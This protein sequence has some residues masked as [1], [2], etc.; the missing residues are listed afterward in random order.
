MGLEYYQPTEELQRTAG[1]LINNHFTHLSSKRVEFM[2]VQSRDSKGNVSAPKTKGKEM[3]GRASV[4]SGKNAWLA[5]PQEDQYRSP[6]K[7]HVVE[8]SKPT[9]DALEDRPKSR[10]ALL[11]HELSHC[12]LDEA[13]E[14]CIAPHSLEDFTAVVRRYGPDWNADAQAFFQAGAEQLPLIRLMEMQA[15]NDS[16]LFDCVEDDIGGHRV[17]LTRAD[18]MRFWRRLELKRAGEAAADTYDAK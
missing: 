14:A 10:E 16:A 15:D 13:G 4:V 3:W 8:V 9:W 6:D 17:R 12:D 1:Y 7:F 5:T 18:L 11:Y 2:M